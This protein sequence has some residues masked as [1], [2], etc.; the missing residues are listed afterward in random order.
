MVIDSTLVAFVALPFVGSAIFVALQVRSY[1]IR[2]AQLRARYTDPK[3]VDAMMRDI[4][5]RDVERGNRVPRLVAVIV[6]LISLSSLAF[7]VAFWIAGPEMM[8]LTLLFGGLGLYGTIHGL[9]ML[10]TG[11]LN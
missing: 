5:A 3:V 4:V 2:R 9:S 8:V 6:A 7:G 11:R 1:R 10:L